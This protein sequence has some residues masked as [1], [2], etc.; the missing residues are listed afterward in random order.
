MAISKAAKPWYKNVKLPPGKIYQLDTDLDK[1]WVGTEDIGTG[2]WYLG[3]IRKGQWYLELGG[4]KHNYISYSFSELVENPE[5]VVDGKVTVIGPEIHEMPPET[6]LPYAL[7]VRCWGRELS[8]DLSDYVERN[9]GQAFVFGEGWSQLGGRASTWLRM[10]KEI[11]PRMSWRKIS[12]LIRA[13]TITNC[14]SVEKV[15]IMWVLGTP[16]VGGVELISKMLEDVKPMWEASDARTLNISDEEVDNFYAC[17]I[18]KL[19]APNH[20]C[21][22]A[23]SIKPYCGV[24]TYSAAKAAY[25]VDP[26]GYVSEVPRGECVDPVA[27]RYAGVDEFVYERSNYK[28]LKYNLYSAIKYP[29]SNCGCFEAVAFYLPQV[30]GIAITA[31]RHSGETPLGLP[32]SKIA[33]I[34]S[35]GA[36][37][38]G[39]QGICVARIK[40]RTFLQ[41]DGGWNRVVWMPKSIKVEVADAIPEEIY[42]KIATEEDTVDVAELEKFLREKRHPIVEKYWRDGKPVPLTMPGPDDLWP[43]DMVA[44]PA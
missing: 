20:V 23:P 9:A 16:E 37:N 10:T 4:P 28:H 3:E 21:I 41:G 5:D 42:D 7:H 12:Q 25:S 43:E 33:G 8:M 32:F 19:I 34:M 18:C 14:P 2:P 44:E 13:Y 39:F 29:S 36:Q 24:M 31:R 38:H 40:G 22:L 15:E 26:Y 6:S 1:L 27:G 11:Q 30:D 17:V 35:G